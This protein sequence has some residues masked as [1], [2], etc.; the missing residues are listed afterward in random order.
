MVSAAHRYNWNSQRS[1]CR[2]T[3]YQWIALLCRRIQTCGSFFFFFYR[4]IDP[5]Y[6]RPVSAPPFFHS[7]FDLLL[8][9]LLDCTCFLLTG[10]DRHS[11]HRKHKSNAAPE[12]QQRRW[13]LE[14][15][16]LKCL[17]LPIC[18]RSSESSVRNPRF[19]TVNEGTSLTLLYFLHR[20]A[21]TNFCLQRSHKLK[22]ISPLLFFPTFLN[23][24]SHT[25]SASRQC[26]LE[27]QCIG[28]ST[29]EKDKSAQCANA[30]ERNG[31]ERKRGLD[32]RKGKMSQFRTARG[33][34]DGS[35]REWG[36]VAHLAAH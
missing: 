36:E 30:T 21:K 14:L 26:S 20:L 5:S 23:L 6:R 27:L 4:R 34:V 13:V 25:T 24:T 33:K 18:D 15:T 17:A 31:G 11:R 22:Q 7:D 32:V 2:L 29:F 1:I 28:A 19:L 3:F 12:L 35:A 8:S 10:L 9:K 16:P